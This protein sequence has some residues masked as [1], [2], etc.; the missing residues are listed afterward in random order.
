M[1]GSYGVAVSSANASMFTCVGPADLP[2]RG[3]VGQRVGQADALGDH[4]LPVVSVHGGALD[5]RGL[6][7]PVGPV[8]RPGARGENNS[9]K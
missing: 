7:V 1:Y 2:G 8:Q 9:E 3:V 6:A 4:H 5:L